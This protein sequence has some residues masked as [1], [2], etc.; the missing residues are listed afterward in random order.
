MPEL[1][2]A[3]VAVV[4]AVAFLVPLLLGLFPRLRP[5]SGWIGMEL[6]ELDQATGAALVAAGL[7][8]VLLFPLAA[9]TVLRAAGDGRPAT[10]PSATALRQ[11]P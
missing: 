4:A 5:P 11:G 10:G 7:L 9:L 2:L 1:S 6:G 8:S 3:G